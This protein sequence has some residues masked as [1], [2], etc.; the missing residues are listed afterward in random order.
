MKLLGTI[1]ISAFLLVGCEKIEG[2]L[3]I[4][5]ELK[6]VNSNGE[7]HSLKLGTYNADISVNNSKKLTLR[8]NNDANEKFV[9]KFNGNIPEN[10]NFA[11][12]STVSG[13]PV[14]LAG[15][16]STV[17]TESAL[18]AS[19]ESC[20]YQR[21]VQVC[22]PQPK[23]GVFCSVQYQTVFGTHWVR[24]YERNTNKNVG[25]KVNAAG[26]SDESA[27]FHGDLAYSERVIVDQSNCM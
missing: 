9:F 20:T 12:S 23:G 10:G 11:V 16:V 4:T 22:Y 1:L 24:F 3:N 14:D 18:R 21:A 2:Q 8:L 26:T 5:K 7:T 25:I 15:T 17:I 13:Q 6:L 19:T 27:D